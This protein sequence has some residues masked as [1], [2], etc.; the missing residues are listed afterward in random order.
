MR[1]ITFDYSLDGTTFV[2]AITVKVDSI[3]AYLMP[4]QASSAS[5]KVEAGGDYDECKVEI[6][7]LHV[8]IIV[9]SVSLNP[10]NYSTAGTTNLVY[11]EKWQC[12]PWRRIYN[13]DVATNANINGFTQFDT[14]NNTN[15]LNID[16][17][18]A[19]DFEDT[20]KTNGNEI[21]TFKLNC[22][23]KKAVSL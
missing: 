12:A 23:T 22:Y 2:T 6:A 9:S 13:A 18:N 16:T 4:E 15:Y 1:N 17:P 11:L 7:R 10:L 8:D 19:P 21:R 5:T 20:A 14:S 3:H